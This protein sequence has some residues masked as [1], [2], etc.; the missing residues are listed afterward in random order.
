MNDK[1]EFYQDRK[2]EWRWRRTAPNGNIVGASSEGY[3]SKS[4]CVSNARRHGYQESLT[5]GS[6]DRWEFYKDNA[7][8]WRW[9]RIAQNGQIVGSSTEG[10]S[11][12]V[13]CE[14]NARRNGYR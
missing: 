12:R 1:W 11:N 4:S 8:K 9:R 7:G 10:Y 5:T 6:T 14:S 13:D 3:K 2:G